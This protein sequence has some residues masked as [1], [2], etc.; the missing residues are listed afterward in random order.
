VQEALNLVRTKCR[1][2]HLPFSGT[3]LQCGLVQIRSKLLS[4]LCAF[5]FWGS[6][7]LSF[8]DRLSTAGQPTTSLKRGGSCFC[9]AGINKAVA[10][11]SALASSPRLRRRF[12]TGCE[13]AGRAGN[14]AQASFTALLYGVDT[15]FTL[16]VLS[17]DSWDLKVFAQSPRPPAR[18]VGETRPPIFKRRAS[19]F[20]KREV[21]RS[22]LVGRAVLSEN[23]I[24]WSLQQRRIKVCEKGIQSSGYECQL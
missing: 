13:R 19:S 14:S 11:G 7:R 5:S 1:P 6:C 24:V 3:L 18:V 22:F 2:A 20:S 10:C 12:S 15:L 21:W 4:D 23:S 8:V 17:K 9:T 16:R